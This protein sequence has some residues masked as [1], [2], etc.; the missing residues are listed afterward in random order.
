M[1]ESA[2]AKAREG[3]P[4]SWRLFLVPSAMAG[5]TLC[6]AQSGTQGGWCPLGSPPIELLIFGSKAC[7]VFHLGATMS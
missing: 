5:I 3:S 7:L 1:G 6:W 2:Q 4:P